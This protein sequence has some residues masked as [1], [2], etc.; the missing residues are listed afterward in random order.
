MSFRQVQT[1]QLREDKVTAQVSPKDMDSNINR[2]SAVGTD[3]GQKV[4][5]QPTPQDM[6]QLVPGRQ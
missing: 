3:G 2:L 1:V 6:E 5:G 4:A